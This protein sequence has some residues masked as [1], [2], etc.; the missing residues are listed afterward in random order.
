[1]ADL[2]CEVLFGPL[3]RC[4]HSVFVLLYPTHTRG[5]FKLKVLIGSVFCI[6][7]G[8]AIGV[9]AAIWLPQ[10][11]WW[12]AVGLIAAGYMASHLLEGLNQSLDAE[13]AHTAP[14]RE[15]RPWSSESSL[16]EPIL[17]IVRH[18]AGMR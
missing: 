1:M 11:S 3:L 13:F 6:V 9:V 18:S 5:I 7:V 12:I 17:P 10:Y 4:L 15:T 8:C 2:I 16:V 14:H